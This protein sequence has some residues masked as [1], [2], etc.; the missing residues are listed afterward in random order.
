MNEFF[1]EAEIRKAIAILKPNDKLFE[2]RILESNK[3]NTLSGYF[4]SADVLLEE[5]C[6][7]GL[8]NRNV[9][10]TLNDLDEACY[11]RS[12]HDRFLSNPTTTSDSDIDG[13]AW[14]FLDFDPV[15]KSGVSSTDEELK[16]SCELARK[17]Y[18]YL[19]GR[20][21]EE[22]VKALSGNGCHLLYKIALSNSKENVELI[23]KCLKSL[24]MMFDNDQVKVDTA[25][26][27][28]SRIC[29]LHGTLAQKG[30]NTE[31]RPHRMSRIF[32]NNLE[33]KKTDKA[34]LEKLA[35]EFKEPER[36]K[37]T[38]YEHEPFDPVKWMDE[39]GIE[40]EYPRAGTDCMIYPLRECVFDHSHQHGDAKVFIYSN[41][42]IAYKCH[43][44]SCSEYHWRDVRL[45]L[46]PDAYD[47]DERAKEDARIEAGWKEHNRLKTEQAMQ[48]AADQRVD[49]PVFENAMEIFNK[50]RPE[51]EYIRTG[52]YK[53]DNRMKGLKKSAIS[54]VSG[55][56]GSAK[57]T[58]LSNVALN[59]I[60]DGQC[61]LMY[62]G[63]LLD[64]NVIKWINRQA[65]GK[66]K[67]IKSEKFE[68]SWY[69]TPD[70][71]RQIAEWMGDLFWL[72][73]NDCGNDF[74]NI[75]EKID[76]AIVEKKVD[77]VI[78]DN[79]MALNLGQ[80]ALYDKLEAQKQF[81]LKIKKIAE[82]RNVHIVFVAHPRKA[83]GFLRLDDVSGTA[84]LTNLVDNAFI[85][86]R[87]NRDF[88]VFSRQA[89]G[90]KESDPIYE[91]TNVIEIAKNRDDG[92]QDYFI[93]LWY[94]PETKR[95]LS[96]RGEYRAYKWFNDGFLPVS[97]EMDPF[98]EREMKN[99]K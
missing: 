64:K 47:H 60:D 87:V 53:I 83:Q 48:A 40:Y 98:L 69:T 94:E 72:Y 31:K 6:K 81:V 34:F 35:D 12:Q 18:Q 27:N 33:V 39:H 50:K 77:L 23:K 82:N 92:V 10:I 63:E 67:V 29:K 97:D 8:T 52:Y 62:S 15:R 45:K 57:S 88:K 43:H 2:C 70:I 91:A 96:E 65:A 93:P 36:P 21:F 58:W 19:A 1:N 17:V 9:Y 24:S 49:V 38:T 89:F 37:P 99:G 20:G 32:S 74:N 30:A 86:H 61:V 56:R 11:S 75:A 85:V 14:L 26:F 13:Y 71:N 73:N 44:N 54:V 95:L 25:N 22:P 42:A 16:A 3:K 79:L 4:T 66:L 80:G 78:L 5:L 7:I 51:E 68:S 90:W 59:A 46:E 55:L 41:G 76:A 84:D 28:P